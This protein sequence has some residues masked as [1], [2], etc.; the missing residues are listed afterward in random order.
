MFTWRRTRDHKKK[1]HLSAAKYCSS[2]HKAPVCVT[3]WGAARC[4]PTVFQEPCDP[5]VPN[6]RPPRQQSS[7]YWAL[8]HWLSS[9]FKLQPGLLIWSEES[10]GER[11][12]SGCFVGWNKG[13][14][15][16][17]IS[18]EPVEASLCQKGLWRRAKSLNARLH[19]TG[20]ELTGFVP[21]ALSLCTTTFKHHVFPAEVVTKNRI[22]WF[23]I[24]LCL[25]SV[26]RLEGHR[27]GAGR[28]N[29]QIG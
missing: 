1:T 11:R 22:P 25:M 23:V 16:L 12:H 26:Q 19:Q 28:P 7:H 17:R 24:Q 8:G 21:A 6:C 2:A 3:S 29:Q 18:Q 13:G 15:Q 14:V 4:V 10:C 9:G 5:P 20:C 27:N